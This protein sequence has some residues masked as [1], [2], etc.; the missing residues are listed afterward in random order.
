MFREAV[1][2]ECERLVRDWSEIPS[3]AHFHEVLSPRVDHVSAISVLRTAARMSTHRREHFRTALHGCWPDWTEA[4]DLA[5][6]ADALD[7]DSREAAIE[8]ALLPRYEILGPLGAGAFGSV[9]LARDAALSIPDLEAR[10]AIKFVGA[11]TEAA[12]AALLAEAALARSIAHPGVARAL[13]AGVLRSPTEP[14]Q[15]Y[16]VS[17]FVDGLPLHLWRATRPVGDRTARL[18]MALWVAESVAACHAVGVTHGDLSPANVVVGGDGRPRLVDFGLAVLHHRDPSAVG[19]GTVADTR[20]LASLTCWLLRCCRLDRASAQLLEDLGRNP[21][22]IPDLIARLRQCVGDDAATR[23][24]LSRRSMLRPILAGLVVGAAVVG[25]ILAM[26]E[27][28][29]DAGAMDRGPLDAFL[30]GTLDPESTRIARQILD[31]GTVPDSPEIRERIEWLRS[32]R[33]YDDRPSAE[34]LALLEYAAGNDESARVY[35]NIAAGLPAPESSAIARRNSEELLAALRTATRAGAHT[36]QRGALRDLG[37]RVRSEGLVRLAE[38][39]PGN[40]PQRPE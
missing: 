13:D 34:L 18:R 36:A 32:T 1:R 31:T 9:Y 21:P 29:I 28:W 10:V 27:S 15:V 3:P 6:A 16:T 22:A 30:L 37:I 40:P 14:L 17:E 4:F 12:A 25:G 23:S 2:D 11:A 38:N 35:A 39:G 8:Q 33:G 7:C 19:G 26:R 5:V 24:A 20:R